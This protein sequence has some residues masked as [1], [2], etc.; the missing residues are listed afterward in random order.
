MKSLFDLIQAMPENEWNYYLGVS[1]QNPLTKPFV[2]DKNSR[3]FI[4]EYFF[5]GGKG[6]LLEDFVLDGLSQ[7]RADHTASLFFLGLTVYYNTSLKNK[8]TFSEE[9][10]NLYDFFQFIWFLTCLTHDVA[11]DRERDDDLLDS[12]QNLPALKEKYV[13]TNDLTELGNINHIPGDMMDLCA[14]YFEFRRNGKK[15]C[16]DHGIHAGILMYDRLVKNRIEKYKNDDKELF[17]KPSLDPQYAYAS[18]TVAV[19]NMWVANDQT[20][21]AYKENKLDALI[22]R[23]LIKPSEAPLLYLLDFVDTIEPVKLFQKHDLTKH[24]NSIEVLKNVMLSFD[25][26]KL[27]ITLTNILPIEIM[28]EKVKGIS[29][30]MESAYTVEGQSIF[31]T[32]P[33]I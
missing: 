11:F 16:V 29:D 12:C 1:S 24:L 20:K 30:W 13:I 10:N 25:G 32:I 9:T 15:P 27:I 28:L 6:S 22:D 17:W 18:A 21:T 7:K 3:D 4:R 19:H 2:S 23:P 31:I 8:I 33:N 26:D 5:K 14:N